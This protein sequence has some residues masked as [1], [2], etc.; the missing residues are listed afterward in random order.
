MQI[1]VRG[2]IAAGV[3]A[4]NNLDSITKFVTDWA[5]D[6]IDS[7]GRPGAKELAEA[8]GKIFMDRYRDGVKNNLPP[9]DYKVGC[10]GTK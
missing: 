9:N 5:K 1:V 2:A 3:M 7:P 10:H 8:A 6:Q 4:L